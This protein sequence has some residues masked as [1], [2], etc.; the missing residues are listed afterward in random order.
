M[1]PRETVDT[2]VIMRHYEEATGCP[3]CSF[4]READF[5]EVD[6]LLDGN[7]MVW[8]IRQDTDTQGFC[9]EHYAKLL[10]SRSRFSVAVMLESHLKEIQNVYLEGSPSKK[11]KDSQAAKVC[12]LSDDCYI[13]R[14]MTR[15]MGNFEAGVGVLWKRREDF[16]RLF[17]EK[18]NLCLT[19][20]GSLLRTCEGELDPKSFKAFGEAAHR[21][22]KA[23]LDLLADQAKFYCGRFDYRVSGA[24]KDFGETADVLERISRFLYCEK[25]P[26]I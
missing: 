13:C 9:H 7:M 5:F 19:H 4:A 18:G 8:D 2:A 15:H 16:R 23:Q 14:R 3:H 6:R 1:A 10:A 20:Y 24:D 21:K 17:E 26:K 22:T 11:G 25:D 12:R